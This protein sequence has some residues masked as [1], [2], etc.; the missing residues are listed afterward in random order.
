MHDGLIDDLVLCREICHRHLWSDFMHDA[1]HAV[2]ERKWIACYPQFK[3]H[4]LY[5]SVLCSLQIGT[6]GD[7]RN[8]PLQRTVARGSS[9]AD[10]LDILSVAGSAQREMP[11]DRP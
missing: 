11:A 10:N 5:G 2:G 3:I 6:V 7:G 9:H 8:F 1:A 4:L